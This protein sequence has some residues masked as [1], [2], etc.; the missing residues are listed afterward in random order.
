MYNICLARIEKCLREEE[1]KIVER[2]F[3]KLNKKDDK[4]I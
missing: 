1:D 4:T 3:N 2:E